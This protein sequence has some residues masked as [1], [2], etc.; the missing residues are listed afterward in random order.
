M[1]AASA[2]LDALDLPNVWRGRDLAQ[3]QERTV[4]TGHPALDA[5][6]PGRG[7]PLGNLVEVLQA[8]A[9][10]HVWQLV[11][12]GLSAVMQ[13]GEPAVLVHPPY[14]PFGPGLRAQGIAPESLLCVHSEKVS[15]RLW[16]TEQ[17][18]RCADVCAVLA[19]LP[20][21]RSEDL[22]RLHLCAQ[23]GEK[24]LVVFRAVSS[25]QH[26][27]PARL[28]LLVAGQEQLEVL[29]LKR[30]GPPMLQPL[31]LR[32]QPQRLS[33]LLSARKARRSVLPVAHPSMD[34]PDV[35]DRTPSLAR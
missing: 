25:R 6:L 14:Q 19:W 18:L 2:I 1:T 23:M 26:S 12:P 22:R 11:G 3:A 10:Q 33:A 21:A 32:S 28:R 4:G 17:A 20:Q 27:S 35:L 15:S 29:I 34:A 24:L 8:E 16:A 7:W 13:S 5:H 30:R 31:V 9:Q